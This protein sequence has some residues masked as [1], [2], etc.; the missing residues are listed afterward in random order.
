MRKHIDH[1]DGWGRGWR[2]L[3]SVALVAA[4]LSCGGSSV[5]ST[6]PVILFSPIASTSV[7]LMDLDGQ[8]LHEW[9]TDNTPGYSVYLLPNG[10]LLRATS[11]DGR[12]FSALQG[13]NGGRVEMLDWTGKATW[14]STTRRGRGSSTTT[15]STCRRTGTC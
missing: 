13:S 15:S 12:P 1:R 8:K 2:A 10:S 7:F 5:G 11:L 14:R 4:L 9:P 6:V 3:G